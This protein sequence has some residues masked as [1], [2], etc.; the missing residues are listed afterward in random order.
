[1]VIIKYFT[2]WQ[3][4]S[5]ITKGRGWNLK[6]GSWYNK[7]LTTENNFKS[8]YKPYIY[9]YIKVNANLKQLILVLVASFCNKKSLKIPM[10]TEISG[11]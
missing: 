4:M 5:V 1:M 7:T 6:Q 3:R 9:F 2:L 10:H 8:S 11:D